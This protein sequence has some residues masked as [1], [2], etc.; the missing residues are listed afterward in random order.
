M[1]I[2]GRCH[3]NQKKLNKMSASEGTLAGGPDFD[4]ATI[5]NTVGGRVA[6]TLSPL[7]SP[8]PCV[9]QPH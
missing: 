3:S 4:F 8:T 6:R 1:L 7:A 5:S 2:L 9:R